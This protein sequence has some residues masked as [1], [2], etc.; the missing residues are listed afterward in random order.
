ME[1]FIALL[2]S[3]ITAT[4][5]HIHT[6]IHTYTHTHPPTSVLARAGTNAYQ[7]AI[8]WHARHTQTRRERREKT[9]CARAG[10]HGVSELLEFL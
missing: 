9:A 4:H 3:V 8:T 6:H 5:T 2:L 1:V 10:D 7:N